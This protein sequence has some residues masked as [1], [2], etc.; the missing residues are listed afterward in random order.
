M[1]ADEMWVPFVSRVTSKA[2]N[3]TKE[4]RVVELQKSMN[5]SEW[6]SSA[7]LA[8]FKPVD[9]SFHTFMQP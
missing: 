3:W 7:W 2:D 8:P 1:R 4:I 9:F 6:N 5:Q